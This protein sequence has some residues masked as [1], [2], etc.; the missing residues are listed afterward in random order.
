MVKTFIEI[1][2]VFDSQSSSE[3]EPRKALIRTDQ[4][5]S[6]DELPG[7]TPLGGARTQ[8]ALAEPDDEVND[9]DDTGGV[10][11]RQRTLLVKESY[12]AIRHE[13]RFAGIPILTVTPG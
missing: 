4:I 10:I 9:M 13:L 5:L 1:T 12:G 2:I 11:R 6:V 8:I 7:R 3:V